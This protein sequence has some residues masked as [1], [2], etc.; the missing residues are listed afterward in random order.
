MQLFL[1]SLGPLLCIQYRRSLHQHDS[2]FRNRRHFCRYL[3]H[4]AGAFFAFR[5]LLGRVP[6]APVGFLRPFSIHGLVRGRGHFA[7]HGGRVTVRKVGNL[8]Y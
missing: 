2:T 5:E 1:H 3:A 6:H 4:R 7:Q 8:A